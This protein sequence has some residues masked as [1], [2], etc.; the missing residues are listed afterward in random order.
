MIG[1]RDDFWVN[2]SPVELLYFHGPHFQDRFGVADAMF[3]ELQK[4]QVK[5]LAAGCTGTSIY[6]VLKDKMAKPTAKI[7]TNIFQV[8]NFI[9]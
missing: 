1:H 4:H 9:A 5:I 8:P 7:L 3:G 2:L 6:L